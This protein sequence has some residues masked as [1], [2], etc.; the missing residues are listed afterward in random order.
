MQQIS[1]DDLFKTEIEQEKPQKRVKHF[2]LSANDIERVEGCPASRV[3][4]GPKA[5]MH[6]AQWYGLFIHRFLE[7]CT[8]RGHANALQYIRSKRNKNVINVCER[9]KAEQIPADGLAELTIAINPT[10]R[11]AEAIDWDMTEPDQHVAGRSDLIFQDAERS[12]RWNVW[13]YKTGKQRDSP[14]GHV[15]LMTNALGVMLLQ[16]AEDVRGSIVGI[17]S[18]SGDLL[19]D[20]VLYKRKELEKHLHRVKLAQYMTL[21]TRADLIEH[22]IEPDIAP[23]PDRC[24]QCRA[25]TVCHGASLVRP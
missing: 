8:T 20:S 5:Q 11:T 17:D 24:F 21:E 13:D 7:Y 14:K 23:S 6:P 12:T 1:L 25:K 10:E 15:Q 22:G 16:E 2:V 19:P 18:Q 3:F 9:I 4:V